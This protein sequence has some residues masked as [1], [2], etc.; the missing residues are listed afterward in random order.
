MPHSGPASGGYSGKTS[1]RGIDAADM[2]SSDRS[3]RYDPT[4]P[5]TKHAEMLSGCR[6]TIK[7]KSSNRS[8]DSFRPPIRSPSS[9]P[10]MTAAPDEPNPRPKGISLCADMVIPG[11]KLDIECERRT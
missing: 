6:S 2:S 10:A 11:G 9:T 5:P 1:A 3:F 4:N 8:L 7:A